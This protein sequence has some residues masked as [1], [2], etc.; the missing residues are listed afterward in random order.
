MIQRGKGFLVSTV[1]VGISLC[2]VQMLLFRAEN[3]NISAP[4]STVLR[5][6]VACKPINYSFCP[7]LTAPDESIV[8]SI[9]LL[10]PASSVHLSPSVSPLLAGELATFS[11]LARNVSGPS[12]FRWFIG[13]TQLYDHTDQQGEKDKNSWQ[14]TLR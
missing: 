6:H 8:K 3:N 4:S 7:I 2:I 9:F 14:S 10:D 11:C 1:V 5:L 12:I 13:Q